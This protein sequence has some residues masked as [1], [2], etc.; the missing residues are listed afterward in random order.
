MEVVF[1]FV[2]EGTKMGCVAIYGAS[3][4]EIK[5]RKMLLLAEFIQPLKLQCM[6][7]HLMDLGTV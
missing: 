6:M 1:S 3:S 5:L 2:S 4:A 7:L